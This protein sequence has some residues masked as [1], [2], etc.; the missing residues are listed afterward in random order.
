MRLADVQLTEEYV[1]VTFPDL[2]NF[3]IFL[4]VYHWDWLPEQDQIN[5]PN[6]LLK[7]H[8]IL[9][10]IFPYVQTMESYKTDGSLMQKV[11]ESK[12]LFFQF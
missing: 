7:L 5:L 12:C 1:V 8:N 2:R 11:Q 10:E 9:K 3:E 6:A 4:R